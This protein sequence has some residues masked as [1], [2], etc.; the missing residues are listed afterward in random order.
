MIVHGARRMR[1][2]LYLFISVHHATLAPACTFM[3]EYWDIFFNIS[4]AETAN[5]KFG[6]GIL[7]DGTTAIITIKL[8]RSDGE[9]TPLTRLRPDLGSGPRQNRSLR[10][11]TSGR[12][13]AALLH[14]G[15]PGRRPLLQESVYHSK[16]VRGSARGF[17]SCTHL[18]TRARSCCAGTETRRASAAFFGGCRLARR[19][20]SRGSAASWTTPSKARRAAGVPPPEEL[21]QAPAA[22]VHLRQQEA[23]GD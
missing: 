6:G 18:A 8:P 5:R 3:Q 12:P 20:L 17:F 13:G 2:T 16:L 7:T 4:Q 14:E 22:A 10:G 15:V 9:P 19:R 11:E 23:A 1:C 21:P